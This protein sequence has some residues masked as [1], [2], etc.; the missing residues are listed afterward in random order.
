MIADGSRGGSSGGGNRV[1]ARLVCRRSRVLSDMW[2]GKINALYVSL[3]CEA[4]LQ[5]KSRETSVA[6]TR[7]D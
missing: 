6:M 1:L 5:V 3:A 4:Y 7:E 2:T